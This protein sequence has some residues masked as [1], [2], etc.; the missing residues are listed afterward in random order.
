MKAKRTISVI[1]S[2]VMA[3]AGAN[4]F[5]SN[6]ASVQPDISSITSDSNVGT[7]AKEYE[8]II[9]DLQDQISDLN[10]QLSR[11]KKQYEEEIEYNRYHYEDEINSLNQQL[12]RIAEDRDSIQYSY[13]KQINDLQSENSNLSNQVSSLTTDKNNLS[14]QVSSLTTENTNLSKQVAS[15]TAE[16]NTLSRNNTAFK[17][18]IERLDAN[19]DGAV[20]AV[21]A[22]ILLS[23]YAYNSTNNS[24][25]ETLSDYFAKYRK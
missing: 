21:D 11:T 9:A 15:L 14:K 5:V 4:M 2:A 6:A 18:S 1:L 7:T 12:D 24:K 17:N 3:G 10:V 25:I 22:S 13:K 20:N 8:K 16:K 19:D 23:I